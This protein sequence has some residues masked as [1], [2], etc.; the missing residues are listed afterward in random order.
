M[1]VDWPSFAGT[2]SYNNSSM[3]KLLN[4]AK[5]AGYDTLRIKG[6]NETGMG[7]PDN[8]HDQIAVL[9]P[10]LIRSEYAK[11]DPTRMH[12]DDIGAATGGVVT[13]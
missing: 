12:E 7:D 8:P 2:A 3:S 5:A 6:M 11:F 13:E 1:I 4:Q 9:N 10:R